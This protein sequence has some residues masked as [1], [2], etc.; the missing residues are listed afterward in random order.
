MNALLTLPPNVRDRLASSLATGT[1]VAP[2]G[3]LSLRAAMGGAL[4]RPGIRDALFEL[5]DLGVTGR[6]AAAWIKT[7]TAARES[8]PRPEL[9]WTG[10]EVPGLH[11]R[12]TRRVFD[13]MLGSAER[14]IWASTYTYYDGLK[15]FKVLADR[16]DQ[17]PALECTLLINIGR[18]WGDSRTADDLVTRFADRFWRYDWPGKRRP[19]VFYDPRGLEGETTTSVL[20][21]KALVQDDRCVLVTSANFTE[22]ALDRNIELG[23]RVEDPAL[24]LQIVRHFARLIEERLLLPIPS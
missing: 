8:V 16:M 23:L 15:A 2:F 12:E 4:E 1:L 14:S 24:A 7:A 10:P 9:V 5:A 3:D 20:H 18:K 21:A 11:A 22:A 6:A 13:E 17:R 19:R